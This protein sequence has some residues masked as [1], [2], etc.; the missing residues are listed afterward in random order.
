ME[1]AA[2]GAEEAAGAAGGS[3][4]GAVKVGVEVLPGIAF[5][6]PLEPFW[7][8]FSSASG[9]IWGCTIYMGMYHV[10]RTIMN[11]LSRTEDISN[12]IYPT[13]FIYP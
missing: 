9:S 5:Q 3:S 6:S 10:P 8:L 2:G 1:A 12:R 13:V 11:V 7:L 4:T